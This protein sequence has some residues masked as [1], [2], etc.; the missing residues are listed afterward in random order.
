[1]STGSV[2]TGTSPVIDLTNLQDNSVR[3]GKDFWVKIGNTSLCQ[4]ERR[5]IL[6]GEWLWGTHLTAVQ[7]LLKQQFSNI[8]GLADTLKMTLKGNTLSSGSVQI[9]HVNGNHWITVS[10]MI[11]TE[12][13]D[14]AIV[15]DSLHSS[16]SHGTKMQL[17][18]LIK[19]SKKSLKIKI[20]S[21]NKQADF[22]DCRV[23]AAVY[24][25][26]LV[27]GQDTSTIVYNQSAIRNHLELCLSRRKMD[28]F[29]SIRC[30]RSGKSKIDS[31]YVFLHLQIT[32]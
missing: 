11:S 5:V 28:P 9:L 24:C 26:A 18:N 4:S 17:A 20:S 16:L 14:D 23:F 21:V 15:Y 29:P 2:V 13:D 31:I 10:T 19:T 30:R 25:T 7:V 22:N 1:M 6:T 27:N 3:Y 32:R 12:N 8:N